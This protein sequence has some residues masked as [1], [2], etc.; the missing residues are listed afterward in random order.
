MPP[1]IPM[2]VMTAMIVVSAEDAVAEQAQRQQ[3]V[4]P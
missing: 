3:G 1:N 4:V 2:P